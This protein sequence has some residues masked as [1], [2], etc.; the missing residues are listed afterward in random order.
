MLRAGGVVACPTDTLY[1]LAVDPR[2]DR[3]VGELYRIKGRLVDKA[4]PLV[5]A[6]REQVEAR[7]GSLNASASALAEAFWPGPL[8]IV[9]PAWPGLAPALLAGHAGVAVRVPAHI[10]PRLLAEA[11]GHPVT[12]TS[13]NLSGQPPTPDPDAVAHLLAGSSALLLDGGLAPGGPPST[14]VD[15]TGA[16]VALIRE[17]AISWERVIAAVPIARADG[18]ATSTRP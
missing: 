8:S 9:I 18:S 7:A 16:Q 3:A 4:I 1:G 14:I 10:I 15:A 11:L 17:G 5:A 2:N 12:S 13:A 6:G